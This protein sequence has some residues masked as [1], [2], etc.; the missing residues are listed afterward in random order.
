M[1]SRFALLLQ[2]LLILVAL[3]ACQFSPSQA[4]RP[5]SSEAKRLM[6]G[7][8]TDED[9]ESVVFKMEGDSVYYPDS[10][11]M[12]A[13]F[14]VI[15]DSL[16]LGNMASYLI[17]K[18][19]EHL[20]WIKDHNGILVKLAKNVEDED[21]TVFEESKPQV[22]TADALNSDTVVYYKGRQYHLYV[23]VNPTK[24][25][26]ECRA[27]NED[28]I[29]VENAYY[30]N[31][32]HVSVFQSGQRLFTQNFNKQHYRQKLPDQFLEQSILNNMEFDG[33]DEHGFHFKAS[34]C[35]PGSA[36]CYQIDHVVSF[37]GK[38]STQLL[39]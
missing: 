20:L 27:V 36:S 9:T 8:W 26:V 30:D 10:T 16:Y 23:T 1:R 37:D 11:S 14:K 38:L 24:S 4:D 29:E 31:I 25:K 19:S 32:V 28:G 15:D 35:T 21:E 33:V 2:V 3:T 12:P 13:Y 18:H 39:E 22:L 6:Q 5:E 34:V 17:V 7:V